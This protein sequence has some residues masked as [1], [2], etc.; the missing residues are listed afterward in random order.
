MSLPLTFKPSKNFKFIRLGNNNDGG[1]LLGNQTIND[2]KTL[3]SF[4]VLDDCSF[5]KDFKEK[6]QVKN[7]MF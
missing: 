4:G 2:T 1:Y 7:F 5:E 3:I 6:N